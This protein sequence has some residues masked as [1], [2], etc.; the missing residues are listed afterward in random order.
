MEKINNTCILFVTFSLES[1]DEE[2][3]IIS[4]TNWIRDYSLYCYNV[5]VKSNN[6]SLRWNYSKHIVYVAI[7][8]SENIYFCKRIHLSFISISTNVF[9]YY[10][11]D[12]GHNMLKNFLLCKF[13]VIGN[14][15]I[16]LRCVSQKMLGC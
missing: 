9:S 16:T 7:A 12:C 4:N 8:T 5:K 1:G 15:K 2:R 13:M 11:L 6:K 3:N 10:N 14:L